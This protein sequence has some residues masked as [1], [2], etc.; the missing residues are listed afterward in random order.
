MQR[1]DNIKVNLEEIIYDI[2]SWADL[3]RGGGDESLTT[4]FIHY[5]LTY[6]V[7]QSPS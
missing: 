3:L 2:V 5:L 4:D 7:V 6:C 1:A